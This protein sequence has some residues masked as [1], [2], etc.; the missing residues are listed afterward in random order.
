MDFLGAHTINIQ[1][2]NPRGT[3]FTDGVRQFFLGTSSHLR[4]GSIIFDQAWQKRHELAT[5]YS[6][7]VSLSVSL[8]Y[9]IAFSIDY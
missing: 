7:K 6:G 2:W 1:C 3:K 5:T 8:W 4:S 9:L